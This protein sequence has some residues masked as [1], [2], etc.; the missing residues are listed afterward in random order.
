MA[1][2]WREKFRVDAAEDFCEKGHYSSVAVP[3]SYGYR[4]K[5]Q[6]PFICNYNTKIYVYTDGFAKSITRVERNYC[7]PYN[8]T[9]YW[10]KDG[11]EIKTPDNSTRKELSIWNKL[12]KEHAVN[13]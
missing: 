8:Y 4:H 12:R 9:T 6:T 13:R 11:T 10:N 1:E 7:T 3:T 2:T 5:R